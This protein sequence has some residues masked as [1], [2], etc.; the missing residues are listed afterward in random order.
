MRSAQ[1]VD[2][3]DL[4]RIDDAHRPNNLGMIRQIAVNLFPQF[5]RELL[6][7]LQLSMTKPLR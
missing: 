5:R 4:E 2:P 6:R 3:V 1:D 7:I